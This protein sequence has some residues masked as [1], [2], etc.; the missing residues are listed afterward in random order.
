MIALAELEWLMLAIQRFL[1][2]R[3]GHHGVFSGLDI[4]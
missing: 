1:Q 2:Y 3:F 4:L